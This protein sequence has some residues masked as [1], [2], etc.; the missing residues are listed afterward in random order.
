[1]TTYD[2]DSRLYTRILYINLTGDLDGNTRNLATVVIVPLSMGA[3]KAGGFVF[4][5]GDH[6]L[7]LT[8]VSREYRVYPTVVLYDRVIHT[9]NLPLSL[10]P[11]QFNLA[12][13][14]ALIKALRE[15]FPSTKRE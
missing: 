15:A 14:E 1:M 2:I 6:L 4:T 11:L 7:M 10:A 5:L 12:A 9:D 3:Q 13:Q 8:V